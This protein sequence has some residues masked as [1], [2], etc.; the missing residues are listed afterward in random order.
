MKV[1]R[2][3][4]VKLFVAALLMTESA[5]GAVR[6]SLGGNHEKSNAGYQQVESGGGNAGVSLDLG[7]YFRI[8]INHREE[9]G[10]TT[11]Y[12]QLEG[13]ANYTYFKTSTNSHTNAY[14]RS[15]KNI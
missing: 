8:G 9:Q 3:M 12:H 1:C 7:E 11:G 6:F 10:S 2:P 4:T 5:Y 14:A 13:T 15:A